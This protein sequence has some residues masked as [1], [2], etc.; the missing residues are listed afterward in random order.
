MYGVHTHTH[1]L[2]LSLSLSLSVCVC[3]CVYIWETLIGTRVAARVSGVSGECH[4]TLLKSPA[5]LHA[6][7]SCSYVWESHGFPRRMCI[8]LTYASYT[9]GER[10]ASVVVNRIIRSHATGLP[11]HRSGPFFP[12]SC[13][14][15]TRR[16]QLGIV[17]LTY[18]IPTN[19]G[20]RAKGLSL[21]L[22]LFL[23]L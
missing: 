11:T 15:D 19:A 7:P 13:T 21:S 3:V 14:Q 6:W 9:H 10:T 4:Y 2:S 22:S 18:A 20:G 1:T 12:P 8:V 17:S 5:I 16:R 23:S